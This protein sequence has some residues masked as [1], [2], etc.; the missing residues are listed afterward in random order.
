MSKYPYACFGPNAADPN[1]RDFSGTEGLRATTRV[2]LPDDKIGTVKALQC[3]VWASGADPA[4][5]KPL[6][7]YAVPLA[8][9]QREAYC[10][11]G[12]IPPATPVHLFVH[13]IA[14]KGTAPA[15]GSSFAFMPGPTPNGPEAVVFDPG[16]PHADLTASPHTRFAGANDAQPHDDER[17]E[18][19]AGPAG[20]GI[21]VVQL[22]VDPIAAA[23]PVDLYCGAFSPSDPTFNEP[24]AVGYTAWA[25]PSKSAS[26]VTIEGLASGSDH[27]L[28]CMAL[29]T[30]RSV[31]FTGMYDRGLDNQTD[32]VRFE[33]A[34][35]FL[36]NGTSTYPTALGETPVQLYEERPGQMSD[37]EAHEE[38]DEEPTPYAGPGGRSLKVAVET[39][40]V[41]EPCDLFCGAFPPE[42]TTFDRPV[43]V[44]K[45]AWEAPALSA[46]SARIEG[47]EEDVDYT[48]ACMARGRWT[49]QSFVGVHSDAL[50]ERAQL[51]LG[52][53]D[54]V[55]EN[56]LV[57]DVN[58]S[59]DR[60]IRLIG[61]GTAPPLEVV[62]PIGNP[63]DP[64]LP[65]QPLEP[66]DVNPLP[67]AASAAVGMTRGRID[68]DAFGQAQYE[69][70][71]VVA[72][73][74]NGMQ[75]SLALV[76]RSDGGTSEV[77]ARWSMSGTSTIHRCGSTVAQDGEL[78][79]VAG[80][81]DD[82]LCLDGERLVAVEGSEWS[83]GTEYRTEAES[84]ARVLHY[85][86]GAGHN[87]FE[88]MRRTGSTEIYGMNIGA[89]I[90]RGNVESV[91]LRER[92]E[93]RHGNYM[94]YSYL[95][96][97]NRQ[98][99]TTGD[100]AARH[101]W[102][103]DVASGNN[104][105]YYL[106][107]I[108]Y[109]G[110][111]ASIGSQALTGNTVLV[112]AAEP[113]RVVRFHYADNDRDAV[114]V[115]YDIGNEMWRTQ[116][117]DRIETWSQGEHVRSYELDYQLS[118][119][120][121]QLTSLRECDGH[122]ACKL[123][124]R[125]EWT[126]HVDGFDAK[127]QGFATS[128]QADPP[129]D[130]ADGLYPWDRGVDPGNRQHWI[131]IDGDGG[132]EFITV[133][134]P[135]E[136][137]V[138][139]MRWLTDRCPG[140]GNLDCHRD[141]ANNG[142]LDEHLNMVDA[143][144]VILSD[145]A[146]PIGTGVP[147]DRGARYRPADF[148]GDGKVD[149]IASGMSN[150][151]RLYESTGE[152]FII[153]DLTADRQLDETTY[154]TIEPIDVSGD[155]L[156]D[157]VE[158][159]G[160]TGTWRYRL[161]VRGVSL[162][163]PIDT[164]V[165]CPVEWPVHI[166]TSDPPVVYGD[167]DGDGATD[168]A[169][170]DECP[171]GDLCLRE[172]LVLRLANGVVD[173]VHTDIFPR[174]SFS[175]VGL[176]DASGDG[177]ADVVLT[178]RSPHDPFSEGTEPSLVFINTGDGFAGGECGFRGTDSFLTD[179]AVQQC[180]AETAGPLRLIASDL[181]PF[182]YD[183]DRRFDLFAAAPGTNDY[184]NARIIQGTGHLFRGAT[185]ETAF[186]L[187]QAPDWSNSII[188]S[189]PLVLD[190]AGDGLPEFRWLY[191]PQGSGLN[192]FNYRSLL[193]EHSHDAERRGHVLGDVQQLQPKRQ[194]RIGAQRMSELRGG[195]LRS[196]HRV[197]SRVGDEVPALTAG[198]QGR[199]HARGSTEASA[200]GGMHSCCTRTGAPPLTAGTTGEGVASAC[201]SAD[202]ASE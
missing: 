85:A 59:I 174:Q 95:R 158:C 169:F 147:V 66:A 182:D 27:K 125:F 64:N 157:L 10:H 160:E 107:E 52:E 123:P 143:L 21:N 13:G 165:A 29:S 2:V 25:S 128:S 155:G 112:G 108:R 124:T 152:T 186:V 145:D 140:P 84:Y 12:N 88:V 115:G 35:T 86:D 137:K 118:Q 122:G 117:L 106:H 121:H 104:D 100:H 181:A 24:L 44:A 190:I 127:N 3:T 18:P 173:L 120:A 56:G 156:V 188:R 20:W 28:A 163:A 62:G 63:L 47:L 71:I 180:E 77:G 22:V 126:E 144:W 31:A 135:T 82:H 201:R 196:E 202:P 136:Q 146:E 87:Y 150:P 49:G 170:L 80:T 92:T 97:S 79:P 93:D 176:F 40:A 154:L 7:S 50:G 148:N 23:E 42:D 46:T 96:C 110:H 166:A 116:H 94:T 6:D 164:G 45:S 102:T 98:R 61:P 65:V 11:H 36:I 149:L 41:N 99:T 197:P 5:S 72:P 14:G 114:W 81:S 142:E 48:V 33:G 194:R 55:F 15:W 8:S 167:V 19:F 68:V 32:V 9:V 200:R 138:E 111:G 30:T 16:C 38:C 177:L 192:E 171:D 131:D 159:N 184:N 191:V 172:L 67:E 161:N 179:L 1:A 189:A 183:G 54:I 193:R 4:T 162:A 89:L 178:S 34:K 17:I 60:P 119:G 39:L 57:K 83:D 132:V 70:P 74:R 175:Y 91:W 168:I 198:A 113:Q 151:I 134:V 69:V 75:P 133:H 185:D 187:G 105:E 101:C 53:G 76:Y 130:Q 195:R 90:Y 37:G 103:G 139:L 78:R 73:G 199:E 26:Y 109:T 43:A 153:R 51:R 129:F 58:V 141:I